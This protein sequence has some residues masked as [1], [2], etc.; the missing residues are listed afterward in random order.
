M[1][2]GPPVGLDTC[3][4]AAALRTGT[5]V[6]VLLYPG[7]IYVFR[8]VPTL[9][10]PWEL[11]SQIQTTQPGRVVIGV[12]CLVFFQGHPSKYYEPFSALLNFKWKPGLQPPHHFNSLMSNKLYPRCRWQHTCMASRLVVTSVKGAVGRDTPMRTGAM[13]ESAISHSSST[14][15]LISAWNTRRHFTSGCKMRL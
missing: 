10:E 5:A 9:G 14:A 1:T 7:L 6:P 8:V 3:S 12:S 15:M 2:A 11:I 13:R 4:A